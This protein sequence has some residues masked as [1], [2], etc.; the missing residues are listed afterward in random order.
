M[1]HFFFDKEEGT[2]NIAPTAKSGIA[3]V[4]VNTC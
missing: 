2:M 3:K 1:T 4:E